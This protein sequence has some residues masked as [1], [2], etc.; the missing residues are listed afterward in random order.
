MNNISYVICIEI[1]YL[2]IYFYVLQIYRFHIKLDVRIAIFMTGKEKYD[3][4]E[5][6][7]KYVEVEMNYRILCA[8]IITRI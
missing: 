6:N 1:F 5:S 3:N 2:F 4:L 8:A 7:K